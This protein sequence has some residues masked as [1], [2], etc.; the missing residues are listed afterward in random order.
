MCSSIGL[1]GSR[2]D[3]V[4]FVRERGEKRAHREWAREIKGLSGLGLKFPSGHRRKEEKRKGEEK[5]EGWG[6]E[7]IEVKRTTFS[8]GRSEDPFVL[9]NKRTGQKGGKT[10]RSLHA[11]ILEKDVRFSAVGM[12]SW[13]SDKKAVTYW[14]SW[15]WLLSAARARTQNAERLPQRCVPLCFQ[16]WR[17]WCRLLKKKIKLFLDFGIEFTVLVG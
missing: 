3:N 1:S 17:P 7:L 5:E 15:W 16:W 9:R 14:V 13:C 11:A 2:V 10:S 12:R 4:R 8:N 6:R